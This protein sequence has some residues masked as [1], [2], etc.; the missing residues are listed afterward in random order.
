MLFILVCVLCLYNV[1]H[2]PVS[3]VQAL[4]MQDAFGN[5][6]E[7]LNDGTQLQDLVDDTK[8][9]KLLTCL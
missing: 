8:Q 1:V 9:N 4:A 5:I 3:P 2:S 7:E 6:F